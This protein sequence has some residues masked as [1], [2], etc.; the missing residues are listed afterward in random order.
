MIR[1]I[2]RFLG[3]VAYHL[4]DAKEGYLRVKERRNICSLSANNHQDY[5]EYRLRK[6]VNH[7]YRTTQFYRNSFD[8]AG[9]KPEDI[10]NVSDITK[11]PVVTKRD[12][13]EGLDSFLSNDFDVEELVEAKTGGS[14][15]VALKLYFDK[16][17]QKLRN[18]AQ[19]YADTFAGWK[20]GSRFAAIWGNPPVRKTV[21][22]KLRSHLLD[23]CIYL[24][25]MN[26]SEKTV[27]DFVKTYERVRPEIVFGH[28][29]SIYTLSCYIE[30]MNISVS[31]PSGIVT[32]SMMLLSRERDKIEKVFGSRVTNRYGC[33]EVGL[34]AVECDK[35]KSFHINSSHVIVE[36]VDE[37]GLQVAPGGVGRIVVTDLNNY[38]MPLI[39]YCVEDMGRLGV[40]LCGCG[41]KSP[42]LMSLEGRTADF[43]VKRNGERVSGV[44]LVERTLTKIPGLEQMQIVQESLYDIRLNVVRSQDFGSEEERELTDEFRLIFGDEV[45]LKII[46]MPCI[47]QEKSGKFRFSIC[48][49]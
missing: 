40:E 12:I 38:G 19:A 24:D 9:V 11:L 16:K 8:G 32:T 49:V 35:E 27:K 34:I 39:R 22:S 1:K 31:P 5:Q 4:W 21:W 43:L 46:E 33:E 48:K 10:H 42:L 20:P 2:D 15:G 23:R 25:T 47:P 6:L 3:F 14:T 28:A 36:I 18:G 13:R 45:N 29:H 26:I 37:N 30:S 41:M 44:S 17:C 7:A